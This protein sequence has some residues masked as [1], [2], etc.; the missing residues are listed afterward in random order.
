MRVIFC[1]ELMLLTF[2][3]Y[4]KTN[5]HH[6]ILNVLYIL[7]SCQTLKKNNLKSLKCILKLCT[8]LYLPL[9]DQHFQNQIL[10]YTFERILVVK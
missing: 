7:R 1:T 6:T 5:H 3:V 2:K 4:V 10:Q 9:V 8:V